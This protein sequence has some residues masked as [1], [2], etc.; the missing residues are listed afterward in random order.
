MRNL[1]FK[2]NAP[3]CLFFRW[4]RN[5]VQSSVTKSILPHPEIELDPCF[6]PM[7]GKFDLFL[8]R[9]GLFLF[10]FLFFQKNRCLFL[11]SIA[12]RKSW[13]YFKYYSFLIFQLF[14]HKKK[15]LE[16]PKPPE[17]D[18]FL[19]LSSLFKIKGSSSPYYSDCHIS[20]QDLNKTSLEEPAPIP[21]DPHGLNP[22]ICRGSSA[23]WGSNGYFKK[24]GMSTPDFIAHGC[25][26]GGNLAA[27]R[28]PIQ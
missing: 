13:A 26:L 4:L 18:C 15:Q 7:L 19:Y 2:L 11:K 10:F 6:C 16:N 21:A 12:R 1:S 25:Q 5:R 14:K 9:G 23:G 3:P 17:S 20:S 8:S 24:L 28:E 22:R 27:P